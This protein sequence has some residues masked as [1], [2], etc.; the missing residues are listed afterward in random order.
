MMK[1]KIILLFLLFGFFGFLPSSRMDIHLLSAPEPLRDNVEN[2]PC[3]RNGFFCIY[4]QKDYLRFAGY[5]NRDYENRTFTLK[6]AKL[7]S[8]I[9]FT[10]EEGYGNLAEHPYI[11][12]EIKY[13][14]GS[15][16]GNG[17]T[18]TWDS[19]L[20]G[21]M[22]ALIGIGGQVINL[23]F[24]ADA[25]TFTSQDKSQGFGMICME[26]KGKIIHCVTEGSMEISFCNAGGIAGTNYNTIDNCINRA[27]ITVLGDGPLY[28]GGIAGKN[29]GI[30]AAC[31]NQGSVRIQGSGRCYAGGIAGF[32]KSF[33][34]T[35]CT[36]QGE[37]S[38]LGNGLCGSGG[39]SGLNHSLIFS[40]ANEGSIT[41][42]WQAGGIAG[43][44]HDDIQSCK[45][46]G[47]VSI[48]YGEYQKDR[49]PKVRGNE[50]GA[51]GICGYTDQ[52][53]IRSCYNLGE[54]SVPDEDGQIAFG[55]SRTKKEAAA[56]E[57]SVC[58]KGSVLNFWRNEEIMML[59]EPEMEL[60]ISNQGQI[61][62]QENDWQFDLEAAKKKLPLIPLD[63]EES[64]L[65]VHY[66]EVYLCDK[67]CLR[68]PVG[69]YIADIS[70][71]ALCLKPRSAN[72]AAYCPCEI[73][74][75]RLNL[76][77]M[78]YKTI[79]NTLGLKN[80]SWFKAEVIS[81]YDHGK[82]TAD[83]LFLITYSDDFSEFGILSR[84]LLNNFHPLPWQIVVWESCTLSY[85]AESYTGDKERYPELAARNQIS[86]ENRLYVGQELILP[87]EWFIYYHPPMTYPYF[88]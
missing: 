64:S 1:R 51:G 87:D 28:A 26:N 2:D 56:I 32:N 78:P 61:P 11:R 73:W 22:F 57:N 43:F 59:D 10:K 83:W 76:E 9:D 23:H 69:F 19:R 77:S 38:V 72:D 40:C 5:V 79:V 30:I 86:D 24:K 46:T 58:L 45:N 3:F 6:Y 14:K 21:P 66:D 60:W 33:H 8:D 25:L 27:K 41:N 52:G 71:Y 42:H 18:I 34:I 12:P 75:L 37:V 16:N 70:P 82:S 62:Y 85:I 54:I 39:I 13:F 49:N 74:L 88:Y 29:S 44:N 53:T 50:N 81:N 48:L 7:F 80:E 47:D 65:T 67:F 36:N 31:T 15:F 20:T 84:E 4:T 35:Y 63:A 68:C 55:I 17:H